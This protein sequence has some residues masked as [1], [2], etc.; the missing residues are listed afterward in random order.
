MIDLTRAIE[1]HLAAGHTSVPVPIDQLRKMMA[2]NIGKQFKVEGTKVKRKATKF[3]NASA[4]IGRKKK[5]ERAAR[6]WKAKSK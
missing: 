1:L 6:A 2:A 3:G 4:N 5:A